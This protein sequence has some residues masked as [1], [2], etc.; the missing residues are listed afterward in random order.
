MNFKV[1]H[2]RAGARRVE[3]PGTIVTAYAREVKELQPVTG[4]RVGIGDWLHGFRVDSRVPHHC[5][6]GVI[7]VRLVKSRES[8][9]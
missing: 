8:C 2:S 7:G 4:L 6:E 9:Y 5:F 3:F 1:V